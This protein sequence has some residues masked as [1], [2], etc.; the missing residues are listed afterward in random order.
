MVLKL[1]TSA[2]ATCGRR[3]AV[4]LHEKN[5]PY[6]LI[7]PNWATKEHKSEA[8]TKNHPFG[9]MPYIDVSIVTLPLH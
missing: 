7:Q 9:Q 6:E 1:Y 5:V 4:I 8:W 2:Q 3:V